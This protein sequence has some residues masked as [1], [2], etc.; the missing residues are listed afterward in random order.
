MIEYEPGRGALTVAGIKTADITASE[1]LTATVPEVRVTST[2][3]ITLDTP[4]VVCTNKLITAS[5]EV[6][7]G[8]VM[9]GN[10]EHSGGK[11]TSNGVQVDNHAHG[12]VQSGGSWTKGTQ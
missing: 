8:G 12:S 1:S 3:R 10:I 4:E 6:Q 9:T 7:Q 2:S 11:F 5:L